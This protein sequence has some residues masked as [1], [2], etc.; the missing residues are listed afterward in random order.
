[1]S[2]PQRKQIIK[3]VFDFILATIGLILSSPLWL[4]TSVAIKIED[5]GQIFF[6]QKRWGRY[7]TVITVRKFRSMVSNAGNHQA[8]SND[9]RVTRV[10]KFMRATGID[11]LPQL[12]SILKGEMSLVG[13]RAL[14]VQ[15]V[16]YDKN[17][18]VIQYKDIP[19]FKKRLEVRPGLT[20]LSTVYRKKNIHPS[21][22]FKYDL[23]YIHDQSF[24]LDL[25]LIFL[26]LLISIRGKWESRG[27]KL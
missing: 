27:N 6:N 17:G 24:G 16:L 9:P 12:L 18:G 23:K 21:E 15:E 4:I 13:P 26:S 11:E 8:K 22:K 3:R 10:G 2:L 14:A 20:S 25:K 1:M 5:G 19:G 7:G